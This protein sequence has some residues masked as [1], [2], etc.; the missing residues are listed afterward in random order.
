MTIRT[1]AVCLAFAMLPATGQAETAKFRIA[2]PPSHYQGPYT[3]T[4]IV[5]HGDAKRVRF[6]CYGG[7]ACA[8]M[9]DL[10]DGVCTLWMPE[11]GTKYPNVTVTA[12]VYD[13]MMRHELGHCNG[14]PPS[15]P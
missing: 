5:N 11:V 1:I 3:G 13:E 12:E 15:H 7:Y 14:W 9:H 6:Q 10:K 2:A 4:L 8:Y